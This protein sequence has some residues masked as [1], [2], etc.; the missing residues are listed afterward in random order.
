M[1]EEKKVDWQQ[2]IQKLKQRTDNRHCAD[3]LATETEWASINLGVFICI[4]C[5]GVHRG[6]GVHVSQIRSTTL[7][8]WNEDFFNEMNNKGNVRANAYWEC[9]LFPFEK[10]LGQDPSYVVFF[11]VF[12]LF[13]LIMCVIYFVN[14]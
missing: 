11:F 13:A 12:P 4:N 5:S 3:C 9:N 1:S 14:P 10:P 7:D 6:L 2:Q 8:E